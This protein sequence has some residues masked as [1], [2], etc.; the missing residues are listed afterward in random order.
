MNKLKMF[1]AAG[2]VAASITALAMPAKP[3]QAAEECKLDRFTEEVAFLDLKNKGMVLNGNK[4]D[5]KV[6][7]TGDESCTKTVSVAT[8]KW[9]NE[10]GTPLESQV[11]Y[12]TATQTFGVGTHTISVEV[13]SCRW[14]ADLVEG[15]RPTAADGTAHYK[16]A[17]EPS[18]T[19]DRLLDFSFGYTLDVCKDDVAQPTTPTTPTS[20]TVTRLPSTGSGNVVASTL[21]ISTVTGLGYSLIRS[22][23]LS[24]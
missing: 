7:V 24:K 18:D 4:L 23:K 12:K 14:Q 11:L 8:W 3:A 22:R 2:V 16:L 10:T 21:A 17:G 1:V 6:K 9:Y 15:S 20:T 13:P 5:V 19:M